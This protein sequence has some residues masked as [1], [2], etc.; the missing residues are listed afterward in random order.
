M[1]YKALTEITYPT[2]KEA[3][4]RIFVKGESVPREERD[5]KTVYAGDIFD[6]LPDGDIDWLLEQGYIEVISVP[7]TKTSK[8]VVKEEESVDGEV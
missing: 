2:N 1:Q 6:D 7:V 3:I 8:Q 5:E 4:E